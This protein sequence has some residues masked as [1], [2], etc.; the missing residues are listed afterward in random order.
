MK[1][2]EFLQELVGEAGFAVASA[3]GDDAERDGGGAVEPLQEGLEIGVAA[4]VGDGA[5]VGVEELEDGVGFGGLFEL[6]QRLEGVEGAELGVELGE[7]SEK[8]SVEGVG[9]LTA[10]DFGLEAGE[11]FAREVGGEM[12]VELG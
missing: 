10:A 9:V 5:V 7:V 4:D 8:E 12:G 11:E 6:G 3:A 2:F 1:V